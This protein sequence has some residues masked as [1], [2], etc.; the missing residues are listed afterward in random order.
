MKKK[1]LILIASIAFSINLSA[2]NLFPVKLENCKTDSFCL[3]CGDIKAGYDENEFSKMLSTLNKSLNLKGIKGA[4]KFQVLIDKKG[5]GCVLSHTDNSKSFI[6]QKIIDELNKFN[7]WI[8]AET[9]GEKIEKTSVNFIFKIENNKLTGE[10]E[11]VD[12]DAFMKSFD[13]PVDPKVS[14]D[15]YTYT[16][17]NLKNYNITVWN[18]KNSDLPNNMTNNIAISKNGIIWLTIDEGLVQFNG[19]NFTRTEQDITDKGKYFGYSSL[20]IDNNDTKWVYAKNN[21]Y[22]YDDKKWSIYT[23]E[24]IGL[25]GIHEVINNPNSNEIYVCSNE[26]L[27]ILKNNKW[28]VLNKDNTKGLPS[29]RVF[30][31]KRDSKNR[32]WIGTYEGT[33]MIDENGVVTN[34]EKTKTLLKGKCISSMDEDP[35]GNLYFTLFEYDRKDSKTLNYVEGIAVWSNN[36]IFNLLSIENSGM[37]SDHANSLVYDKKENVLWITTNNAGLV[38]YDLKDGWENYHNKNSDIP[39]SY[40]SKVI[41]DNNGNILLATRQGLVKI[42]KK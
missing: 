30:F 19:K 20:A 34:F 10:I 25:D 33:A 28:S 11:R 31:V 5:R 2:Q 26:G 36:G 6:S 1:T 41:L 39:T 3:D 24:D 16:N 32:L 40:I 9:D 37:P 12:M 22:S 23:S 27:A 4:V 8:P 18:S 21:L 14:N 42:E 7:K 13:K 15:H 35:K 38:R 17:D 29:N